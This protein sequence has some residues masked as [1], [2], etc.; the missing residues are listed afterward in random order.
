MRS[1]FIV[2]IRWESKRTAEAIPQRSDVSVILRIFIPYCCMDDSQEEIR[3]IL[4]LKDFFTKDF[5]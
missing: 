4:N 2:G 3:G 5:F 1:W